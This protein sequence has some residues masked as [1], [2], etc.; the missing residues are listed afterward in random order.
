MLSRKL[1]ICIRISKESY[2]WSINDQGEGYSN[3][4]KILRVK[5]V[6]DGRLSPMVKW[7]FTL[8]CLDLGYV[9]NFVQQ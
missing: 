2:W 3:N 1:R 7:L 5:V 8:C 4:H 9:H 6:L